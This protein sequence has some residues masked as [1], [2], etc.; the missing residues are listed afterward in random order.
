[1]I[2]KITKNRIQIKIKIRL[3][4]SNIRLFLYIFAN[5][6]E[7]FGKCCENLYT[8]FSLKTKVVTYIF[9]SLTDLVCLYFLPLFD[10]KF[11]ILNSLLLKYRWSK[12][13]QIGTNVHTRLELET[14]SIFIVCIFSSLEVD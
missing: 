14:V 1:M 2:F 8:I 12:I 4:V 6:F 10:T 3:L 11:N 5:E 7:N 13:P 9:I